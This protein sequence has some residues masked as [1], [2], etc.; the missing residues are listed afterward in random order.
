MSCVSWNVRRTHIRTSQSHLVTMTLW[1]TGNFYGQ[2]LHFSWYSLMIL[3]ALQV[4][5]PLLQSPS[6]GQEHD[7]LTFMLAITGKFPLF[8]CHI[9]C[10]V[11]A[12]RRTCSVG[13]VGR[14]FQGRNAGCKVRWGRGSPAASKCGPTGVQGKPSVAQFGHQKKIKKSDSKFRRLGLSNHVKSIAHWPWA[15]ISNRQFFDVTFRAKAA[16]C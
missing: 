12:F 6:K 5:F 14:S 1:C 13:C 9:T 8:D 4:L 7:I 3:S 15:L 16:C 11:A 2:F 10:Q